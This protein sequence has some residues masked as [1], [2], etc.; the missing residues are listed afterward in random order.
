MRAIAAR[1]GLAGNH[2]YEAFY[3]L[4]FLDGDGRPL[5][6]E[7]AMCCTSTSRRRWTASGR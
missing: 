3:P 1:V 2:A 5:S 7:H 6:G 4:T